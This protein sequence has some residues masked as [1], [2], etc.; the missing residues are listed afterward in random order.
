[1]I[2]FYD[3][4]LDISRPISELIP[5]VEGAES[6]G[7]ELITNAMEVLSMSCKVATESLMTL[8]EMFGIETIGIPKRVVHLAKYG[9]PRTR[10]KNMNRILKY[11]VKL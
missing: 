1:M 6:H 10:K 9:K 4:Q 7:L 2:Y 8:R 5:D 11:E 3:K